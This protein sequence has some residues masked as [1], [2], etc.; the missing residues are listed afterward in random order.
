MRK[1]FLLLCLSILSMVACKKAEESTS[2]DLL[3]GKWKLVK[4]TGTIT[5]NGIET[6]WNVLELSADKVKFYE[7]NNFVTSGTYQLDVL[8]SKITFLFGDLPA[9]I[10]DIRLDPEKKY[11]L[12]GSNKLMLDSDCCDRVNYELIKQ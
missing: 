7:D 10:M 1:S 2:E 3:I 5:G 9:N 12:E 11:I 6:D 4:T 8:K